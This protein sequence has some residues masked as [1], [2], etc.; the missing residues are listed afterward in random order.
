[1]RLDH[2]VQLPKHHTGDTMSNNALTTPS[3]TKSRGF[4][5]SHNTWV[6]TMRF[7]GSSK[8]PRVWGRIQD[9]GVN[10]I[11]EGWEIK[12]GTDRTRWVQIPC[13]NLATAQIHLISVMNKLSFEMEKV[14]QA[15]GI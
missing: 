11:V 3:I 14:R 5:S 2:F 1:M 7:S 8:H 4:G 12:S 10:F 13:S 15:N 9:T 6:Q